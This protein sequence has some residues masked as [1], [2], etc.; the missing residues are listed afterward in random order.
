MAD[1][2]QENDSLARRL[3][4]EPSGEPAVLTR[5]VS[6]DHYQAAFAFR[7]RPGRR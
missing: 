1:G 5:F 7:L 3:Q 4:I 2:T 6:T